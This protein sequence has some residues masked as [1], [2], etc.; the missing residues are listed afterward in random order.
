MAKY[1]ADTLR[2]WATKGRIGTDLRTAEGVRETSQKF[3]VKL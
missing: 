2:L 3:T 1:G